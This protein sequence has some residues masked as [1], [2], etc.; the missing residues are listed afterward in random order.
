MN[1]ILPNELNRRRRELGLTHAALAKK[2]GV[3][4]MTVKRILTRGVKHA[5]FGN[6]VAVA[7]ALAVDVQFVAHETSRKLREKLARQLAKRIVSMVQS[8]SALESQAVNQ[9]DI[10]DMVEQTVHELMSGS[11]RRL[12]QE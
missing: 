12:W 10:D 6:V 7:Q 4:L 9:D 5:N 8:T 2:S 1:A 3:S 11:R